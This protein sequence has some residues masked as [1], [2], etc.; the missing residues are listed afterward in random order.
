MFAGGDAVAC[1]FFFTADDEQIGWLSIL[2][3]A[4]LRLDEQREFTDC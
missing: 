3:L 1:F 2:N 4:N